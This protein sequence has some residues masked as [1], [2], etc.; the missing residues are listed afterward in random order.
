MTLASR[1]WTRL[2]ADAVRVVGVLSFLGALGT[3]KGV[4]AALFALVLLALTLL[5]LLTRP[6]TD[7][8]TG[9]MLVAGAWA[10]LLDL[11]LRY[12]WLDVPVHLVATGLGAAALFEALVALG[13]LT[14]AGAPYP[15]RARLGAAV[16]VAAL[17]LALGVLW[18]LGE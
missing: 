11:Y 6:A 15:R 4:A 14:G 8:A 16:V 17:G 12:S 10:S 5:R 13:V 9:L 7:A 18:E 3:G 2:A 1:S